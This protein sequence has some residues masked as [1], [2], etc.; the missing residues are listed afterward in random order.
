MNFQIAKMHTKPQPM[1]MKLPN[2]ISLVLMHPKIS[3]VVT[4]FFRLSITI[5]R[6]GEVGRSIRAR[7]AIVLSIC[8]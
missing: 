3:L 6:F 7:T 1:S 8:L 5:I 4:S 2:H